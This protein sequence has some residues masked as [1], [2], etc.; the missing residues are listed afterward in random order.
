MRRRGVFKGVAVGLAGFAILYAAI[1]LRAEVESPGSVADSISAEVA[2]IFQERK[3]TVV[4]VRA[5]DALGLRFGSGF[6]ADPSGTIFTHAGIV[7]KADEVSVIHEGRELPAEVLVTDLRSGIALLKVDKNSPFAPIGDSSLLKVTSPVVM[8]GFPEDMD[9]CPSFGF[10]AGFD[11]QYLGQYFSTTHIRANLPVQRGQGGAPIFNMQGEAVGIL[12][13]RIEGGA[14]C[15]ILPIRAAEKVRL[16]FVR[17]GELRPGWVGVEVEDG[18]TAVGGSSARVGAIDPETPAA[19]SGLQQGDVLVRIGSTPITTS[20]DVLDASYFLTAGDL[21]RIEILRNG[22]PMSVQVKPGRHPL[23]PA[24][25]M[26]AGGP[27]PTT[28]LRLE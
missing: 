2:K 22:E 1:P 11:R 21:A 23:V 17:F 8:L 9:L 5:R 12:V 24:K 7:M 4:K 20:E 13:G 10:V 19:Q 28:P 3:S 16:D 15:H 14:A 26:Q 6:F 25:E 18:E 27:E